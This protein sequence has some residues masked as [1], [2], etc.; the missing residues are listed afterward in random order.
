MDFQKPL[1]LMASVRELLVIAQRRYN[2]CQFGLLLCSHAGGGRLAHRAAI[3]FPPL[4]SIQ[5][6]HQE[7]SRAEGN[8]RTRSKRY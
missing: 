6:E 5:D 7:D 8:F 2:S 4:R 3:T 1:P